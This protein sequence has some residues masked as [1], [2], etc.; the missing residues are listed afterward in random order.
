MMNPTFLVT[1]FTLTITE[2][3]GYVKC[4]TAKDDGKSVLDMSGRKE[5]LEPGE[6]VTLSRNLIIK[7]KF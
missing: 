5:Y 1:S 6:K 2:F 4:V 7:F 3:F